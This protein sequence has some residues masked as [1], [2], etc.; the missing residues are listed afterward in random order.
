MVRKSVRINV[1]LESRPAALLVQNAGKFVSNINFS[2]ND[3]VINAKSIMGVM[4]LGMMEN[5][6]VTII[7]DGSDEESAVS[8]LY[9]YLENL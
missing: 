9:S 7:A 4:S 5:D 1:G 3:K 8:E 6:L 2:V